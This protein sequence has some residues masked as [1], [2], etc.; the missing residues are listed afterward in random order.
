[1][2][3]DDLRRMTWPRQ[4]SEEQMQ[5]EHEGAALRLGGIGEREEPGAASALAHFGNVRVSILHR[6]Q[7]SAKA[8]AL[9]FGGDG[10]QI[11]Q[12][13]QRHDTGGEEGGP[14]PFTL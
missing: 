1:M 7:E 6:Q 4:P 10:D 2:K 5:P 3:D 9:T 13:R 14:S 11:R 8:P 12:R